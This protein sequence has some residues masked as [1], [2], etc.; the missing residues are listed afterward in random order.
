[1]NKAFQ[2][3]F[4]QLSIIFMILLALIQQNI[5]SQYM[6]HFEILALVVAA[7]GFSVL[8]DQGKGVKID[9]K[10]VI[11]ILSAFFIIAVFLRLMPYIDNQ[12]PLGYDP[13][14]YRY[15]FGTYQNSLP[16]IIESG[17]PSWVK[18]AHEPGLFS[19]MDVFFTFGSMTDDI[20][21]YAFILFSAFIVFPIF[22]LT[23]KYS[24]DITALF[25]S[26]LFMISYTQFQAYSFLY[27]KNIVALSLFLVGLYLLESKERL[28]PLIL[29]SV[30]LGFMH[31]PTFFIFFL[32]L[33]AHTLLNHRDKLQSLRNIKLIAAS[34][35]SL[36]FLY[37]LRFS[38]AIIDMLSRSMT[39]SNSGLFMTLQ[40]YQFNSLAYLPF[41]ILG[42]LYFIKNKM[43]KNPIFIWLAINSIIV[44]FQ[45]VFFNRFILHL[46]IA[47]IIMAGFGLYSV[48]NTKSYRKCAAAVVVLS[49]LVSCWIGISMMEG[50]KP[51]ISDSDLEAIKWI[52]NSTEEDAY[53]MATFSTYSPWILG[54]SNRTTIAPGLFEYID[55]WTAE[56]WAGWWGTN[57]LNEFK[58]A[59]DD[60]G[61]PLY[62][63][64]GPKN[65]FANKTHFEDP[66]FDSVFKNNNTVIYKYLC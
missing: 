5:V 50:A 25:A 63:Y 61:R 7:L 33:C 27:Y 30:A 18:R 62:I 43:Y 56:R 45:L 65:R 2:I 4:L 39:S 59:L 36:L 26:L 15:V 47:M 23:R 53:V 20:L 64:V 51:L 44:V 29:I 22:L 46:D 3:S 21:K 41:A 55:Y 14:I 12:I 57:D 28:L 31:R 40:Q 35:A 49:I 34:G 19:F 54:Y 60:Y 13:G 1:M 10:Y 17:L 37:S 48:L 9:K 11:I 6:L 58:S 16:N 24:N 66:C 32:V 42:A 8:H 38:D 52:S